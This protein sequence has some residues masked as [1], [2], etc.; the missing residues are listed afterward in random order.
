MKAINDIE[1]KVVAGEL[2]EARTET[3]TLLASGEGWTVV[4]HSLHSASLS[5]Y[6]SD[7]PVAIV[8]F[9]LQRTVS[10]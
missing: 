10:A 2:R 1:Q 3:N 9:V 4:S 8:I 7:K 6:N 5:S